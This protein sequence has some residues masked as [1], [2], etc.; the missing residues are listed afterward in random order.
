MVYIHGSGFIARND[1]I[2]FAGPGFLLDKNIVYVIFNY[3]LSVFGFLS[4]GDNAAPGNFGLKDQSLALKWVKDN[5][6][7]F[8]GD[9]EKVTL[10]GEGA[11]AECAALHALSSETQRKC[12][13][14]IS[15]TVIR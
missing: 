1:S 6:R 2:T 14:F 5:I 13:D 15:I 11:G 10:F 3:R 9:P 12:L 4:T 7:H 8:G